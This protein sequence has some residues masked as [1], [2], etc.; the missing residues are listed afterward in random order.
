MEGSGEERTEKVR[1]EVRVGIEDERE[2][3]KGQGRR[4]KVIQTKETR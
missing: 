2:M 4:G 3:G 1:I